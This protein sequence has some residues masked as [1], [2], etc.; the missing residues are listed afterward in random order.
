MKGLKM[1]EL[2]DNAPISWWDRRNVLFSRLI[3]E[4]AT[5]SNVIFTALGVAF[6]WLAVLLAEYIDK[7]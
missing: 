1:N 2:N 7:S 3:G 6:L 4:E 5:N